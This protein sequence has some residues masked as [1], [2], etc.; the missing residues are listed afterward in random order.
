MAQPCHAYVIYVSLE[1][2]FGQLIVV[3]QIGYGAFDPSKCSK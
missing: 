3:I 1:G 2:E